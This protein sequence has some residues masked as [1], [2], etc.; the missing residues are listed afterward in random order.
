MQSNCDPMFYEIIELTIDAF[1]GEAMPPLIFDLY[2]MDFGMLGDNTDFMGR[3]VLFE[4]DIEM[5]EIEEGEDD[6]D[7][8]PPNPKWHDFKYAQDAPPEGKILLSFVK[9]KEFDAKW[10]KKVD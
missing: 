3:A 4:K 1:D 6:D 5:I 9:M 7:F 10:T 2:D 8:K